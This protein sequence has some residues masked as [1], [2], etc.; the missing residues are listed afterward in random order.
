[1]A[2]W[3]RRAARRRS[4][5]PRARSAQAVKKGHRPRRTI[6]FAVWD[7]E[8][9][10]ARRLDAVG[11][12]QRREPAQ[13]T[14]SPTSTSTPACRAAISSAA[15]RRRSRQFLRDVTKS[16][17]TRSRTVRSTTAGPRASRAACRA[18]RRSSARPTTPRSRNTSASP[19]STCI[20]TARTASIT[21]CTTTTSARARWSIR[22]SGSASACRGSG[23]CWPGGSPTRKILP[24]RYSDYARAS[25]G[26]IE[27]VEKHAGT[28]AAAQAH[29]GARGCG[30]LGGGGD[31]VRAAGSRWRRSTPATARAVNDRLMAGRARAGRADRPE[32]PAVHPPPA[33]RA[34]AELSQRLPAADLGRP[35]PRRPRGDSGARG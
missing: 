2:R 1:M 8:E 16:S 11:P 29:G 28:R 5:R 33:G 19:A 21:R 25:I 9:A 10:A 3:I 24:M 12:R 27:A 23:A 20:S 22:A 31:G 4:S 17:R 7:G 35:G 26:Y 34:A 18:S 32:R 14:P 13:A 15:R 6:V 30:A